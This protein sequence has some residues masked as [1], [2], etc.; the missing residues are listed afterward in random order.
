M[1][2]PRQLAALL[3][4]LAAAGCA[5][6]YSPNTYSANAVQQ[7]NKVER[8]VVIG[9][10]Q[11]K[12]S[13]SGTVGAVAGG[14]TGGILGGTAGAQGA[15]A[16][17][18][19]VGGTLVGGLVGSA[20]EHTAGDTIGW[21]YI[22]KK[23]GGELVSVTQREQTP[24]P[25]G[26]RVLVIAGNQARIVPDYAEAEPPPKSDQTGANAK[27]PDSKETPP[28]QPT[29]G[30]SGPAPGPPIVLTPS[31]APPSPAPNAAPQTTSH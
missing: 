10:R 8:G 22:V 21:E 25:I 17:L 23:Q 1:G 5:P 29:A 4:V 12:I 9:Y 20:V 27:E 13:A 14:A 30:S 11:V 26:Q 16:A 15:S 7:A 19:A 3:C 24:L 18:G 6:D 31:A 28:A 2:R